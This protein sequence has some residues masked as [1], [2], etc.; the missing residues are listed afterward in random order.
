VDLV[1]C[2]VPRGGTA[3][4]TFDFDASAGISGAYS[5][6]DI[7]TTADSSFGGATY[8]LYNPND[9]QSGAFLALLTGPT[10][11]TELFIQLPS[12]M[13]GAGGTISV[14]DALEGACID[15]SCGLFPSVLRISQGLGSVTAPSGIPE[16]SSVALL[17]AAMFGLG[18]LARKRR[19]PRGS[20]GA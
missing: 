1:G 10:S 13:T 20:E 6:I 15:P 17:A 11:A 8:T 16:P 19:A 4:G 3:S 7:T 14:V 12:A 18:S 5:N 9:T 2:G